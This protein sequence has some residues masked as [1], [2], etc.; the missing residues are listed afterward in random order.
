MGW[1]GVGHRG[2]PREFPG[3]TLS[4]FQRAIELGCSMVECDVRR[5]A[6]NVLVLA[7]DPHVTDVTDCSYD[8]A[9]ATA[10]T[11]AS[12]DLGAG[13]GVPTLY[14]L[15]ELAN[16]RCAVMADMKCEGDGVEEG[17]VEAL[18]RLPVTAK[19]VPGAGEE[20]RRRFRALDSALPLSLSLDRNTELLAHPDGFDSLLP[21]I[22]TDAVTWEYPLL[23]AERITRLHERNL[24]VFA[25]TVDDITIM[26][27][28]IAD[29]VDGIISNWADLLA[30]LYSSSARG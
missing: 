22:D 20:S 14:D 19:I 13:E 12:I 1:I 10:A 5:S 15:V 2:T 21:T 6:D 25:W 9:A 30:T 26:Q 18:S 11:L 4:G 16:G 3:N 28:L 27:R 24:R 8:I 7:H 17:V 29:G 23:N